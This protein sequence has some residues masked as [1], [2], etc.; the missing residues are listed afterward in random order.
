MKKIYVLNPKESLSYKEV[1]AYEFE[2]IKT[3]YERVI[4]RNTTANATFYV[5]DF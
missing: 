5:I 2:I 1:S 4:E 3:K